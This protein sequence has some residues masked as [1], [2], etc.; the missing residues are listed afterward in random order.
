TM[1]SYRYFLV[2]L[3]E[4]SNLFFL[5]FSLSSL[6]PKNLIPLFNQS[7][8]P[9]LF[10][11][12]PLNWH[13][14]I[15]V[16]LSFKSLNVSLINGTAFNEQPDPRKILRFGLFKWVLKKVFIFV[17]ASLKLISSTISFSLRK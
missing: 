1:L 14:N 11:F 4:Y 15:Q 16:F 7:K 3:N 13:N 5:S 17:L 10:L 6:S 9:S 8:Y 12:S 2:I